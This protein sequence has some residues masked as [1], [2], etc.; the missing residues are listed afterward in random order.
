[1]SKTME[2]YHLGIIVRNNKIFDLELTCD[3]MWKRGELLCI[4]V[5]NF[6]NIVIVAFSHRFFRLLSFRTKLTLYICVCVYFFFA[7]K[8]LLLLVGDFL[9]CVFFSLI[10]SYIAFTHAL[11]RFSWMCVCVCRDMQIHSIWDHIRMNVRGKQ[12][13]HQR[14]TYTHFQQ[15]H[16]QQPRPQIALLHVLSLNTLDTIFFVYMVGNSTIWNVFIQ[17]HCSCYCCCCFY[18]FVVLQ[19]LCPVLRWVCHFLC[20]LKTH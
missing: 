1:M 18:F 10:L 8:L 9:K 4:A 6:F 15:M 13:K 16:K 12:K 2:L 5:L 3:Y 17:C 19:A 11:A 20:A 14:H 7:L